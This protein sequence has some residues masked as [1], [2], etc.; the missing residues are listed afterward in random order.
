MSA[1][2]VTA[3][4]DENHSVAAPAAL[5]GVVLLMAAVAYFILA[6]ILIRDNGPESELAKAF[7]KDIKGRI[8]IVF[9]TVGIALSL[10]HAWLAVATYVLVAILWVVPDRRIE[11]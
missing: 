8:S 11:K 10:W 4:M 6:R 3:W 2:P 1:A 9:Y 7:G 5:Y